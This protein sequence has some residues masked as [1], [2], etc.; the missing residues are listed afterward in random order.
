[1]Q[2]AS[3][4]PLSEAG[5]AKD[6]DALEARAARASTRTQALSAEAPWLPPRTTSTFCFGSSP[7]AWRD[8]G[9]GQPRYLA[10]D[11]QPR[12]ARRRGAH[13]RD[14]DP[15][16]QVDA[17][18]ESPE[19]ADRAGRGR[20]WT[21]AAR[22]GCRSMC[23]ATSRRRGREAAKADDEIG[24][25]VP[26][27]PKAEAERGNLGRGK[28][29]HA[30]GIPGET[31]AR[32]P[33]E[34]HVAGIFRNA[35]VDPLPAD[36]EPASCP[37]EMRP[38]ASEMPGERCPPV[39]PQEIRNRLTLGPPASRSPSRQRRPAP[40]TLRVDED[41]DEKAHEQQVGQSRR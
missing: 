21:R 9:R 11:G 16:R 38:S 33:L 15:E 30:G 5:H 34:P 18:R 19:R 3:R 27:E 31:R 10:A 24:P 23:A 28:P 40:G 7:S 22:P 8:W 25:S 17:V 29:R 1:M 41:P 14:P 6:L 20:G 4:A 37:R 39:P 13:A 26:H 35:G 36:K 32:D 2:R 12:V